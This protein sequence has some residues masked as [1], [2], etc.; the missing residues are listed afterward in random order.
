MKKFSYD[1]AKE[2]ENLLD[3]EIDAHL[4]S[5]EFERQKD[6]VRPL[7]LK[8]LASE[9]LQTKDVD[10]AAFLSMGEQFPLWKEICSVLM[11]TQIELRN[12]TQRTIYL[13]VR[14][15]IA[16]ELI[17]F[18]TDEQNPKPSLLGKT[19]ELAA[20]CGFEN[21][22]TLVADEIT[23]KTQS[24]QRWIDYLKLA[25]AQLLINILYTDPQIY[26]KNSV[27]KSN[28]EVSKLL[29][30]EWANIS[31]PFIGLRIQDQYSGTN[32]FRIIDP[33]LEPLEH[34]DILFLL[35][36]QIWL[37]TI[38]VL[39]HPWLAKEAVR[40]A[41]IHDHDDLLLRLLDAAPPAFDQNGKWNRGLAA[42]VLACEITDH[43]LRLELDAEHCIA[44]H[45][46]NKEA[47]SAAGK[48]RDSLLE[49]AAPWYQ[50]AIREL[51]K[52]PDGKF[53]S[54]YLL[55]ETTRKIVWGYH[56]DTGLAAFVA[57]TCE[58]GMNNVKVVDFAQFWNSYKQNCA[59]LSNSQIGKIIN[60]STDE[61]LYL[62]GALFTSSV[63]YTRDA[64]IKIT[65]FSEVFLLIDQVKQPIELWTWFEELLKNI[66]SGISAYFHKFDAHKLLLT[67]LFSRLLK[68]QT[69]PLNTWRLFYRSLEKYRRL[70]LIK[71]NLSLLCPSIWMIHIGLNLCIHMT[72]L[73]SRPSGIDDLFWEMF[74]SLVRLQITRHGHSQ[75]RELLDATF[76][77]AINSILIIMS[78]DPATALIKALRT[79]H[80][81]PVLVV[82]SYENLKAIPSLASSIDTIF[83]DAQADVTASAQ[84]LLEW[85]NLAGDHAPR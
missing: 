84:L 15:W 67:E 44:S 78:A 70:F 73:P 34:L 26:A 61:L 4:V 42:V 46:G 45:F 57:V 68:Q 71:E 53:L 2:T 35:D 40:R 38:N 33:W 77:D 7:L 59:K 1:I 29:V 31:D 11:R 9:I 20:L 41:H 50:T 69:N 80:N 25:P 3:A 52:R 30:S 64:T 75:T 28:L 83:A 19:I 36:N 21:F 43:L 8:F 13:A 81:L 65:K 82:T 24:R 17:L 49:N 6:S 72:S 5:E 22:E 37:Q 55:I 14:R 27:L 54:I 47:V 10:E 56:G 23:K 76:Y 51:L 18:I 32:V 60:P 16:E 58:L 66:D 74:F 12:A 48:Y 79:V 63:E 62:I 39:P 85:T